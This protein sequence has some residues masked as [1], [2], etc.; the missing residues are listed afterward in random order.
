MSVHRCPAQQQQQQHQLLLNSARNKRARNDAV[1]LR[2]GARRRSP[3]CRG[4]VV[5]LAWRHSINPRQAGAPSPPSRSGRP[6]GCS[7]T[8]V[9]DRRCSSPD[10]AP[11]ARPLPRELTTQHCVFCL[12]RAAIDVWLPRLADCICTVT[13]SSFILSVFGL[14]PWV[15]DDGA[16]PTNLYHSFPSPG[17][18]SLPFF[19]A[20]SSTFSSVFFFV[21]PDSLFYALMLPLRL[22]VIWNFPYIRVC[23]ILSSVLVFRWDLMFFI[24]HCA[25]SLSAQCIVIGLVCGY[26]CLFVCGSVT[27]IN[28]NCVHQSSPIWVCR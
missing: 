21:S 4:V 9:T 25:L 7:I 26:V 8:A 15:A 13:V 22:L 6:A 24:L 14:H 16:V 20:S 12:L 5:W 23:M 18:L 10:S 11:S 27:T 3:P 17:V 2:A 1:N 28:R 19:C